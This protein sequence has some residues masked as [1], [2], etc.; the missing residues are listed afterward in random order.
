MKKTISLDQVKTLTLEDFRVETRRRLDYLR[1][2]VA[3]LEKLAKTLGIANEPTTE[4]IQ[5]GNGN[6]HHQNGIKKMGVAKHSSKHV[7]FKDAVF[8]VMRGRGVMAR[9]ELIAGLK[10]SGFKGNVESNMGAQFYN[11][12]GVKRK[13]KGKYCLA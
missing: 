7:T 12:P 4:P 2:E 9:Q 5:N 1:R 8:D 10:E 13:G 11:I 6:G 3:I